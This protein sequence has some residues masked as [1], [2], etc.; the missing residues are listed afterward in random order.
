MTMHETAA[1]EVGARDTRKIWLG[2]AVAI[3]VWVL[4]IVLFGYPAVILGA[5]G[6]TALAYGILLLLMRGK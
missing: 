2:L 6:L 5:L 1:E 4:T 3:V